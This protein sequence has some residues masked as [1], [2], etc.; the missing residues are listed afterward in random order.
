MILYH[1]FLKEKYIVDSISLYFLVKKRNILSLAGYPPPP[2][3][4]IFILFGKKIKIRHYLAYINQ[5]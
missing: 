1:Q 3:L 4:H 5:C 2:H